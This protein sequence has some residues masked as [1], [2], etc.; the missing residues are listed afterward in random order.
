MRYEMPELDSIPVDAC[1]VLLTASWCQQCKPVAYELELLA[2]KN[3]NIAFG[4]IDVE[5]YPDIAVRYGVMTLPT[6]IAKDVE[7]WTKI[8]SGPNIGRR[9][10]EFV[11]NIGVI[12]SVSI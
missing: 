5:K 11:T 10:K 3:P 2:D 1:I 6:V 4:W 8:F 9:V 7:G 12:T